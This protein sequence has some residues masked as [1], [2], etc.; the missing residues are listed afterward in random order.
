[1]P[2]PIGGERE[3]PLA[4]TRLGETGD[5]AQQRGLAAAGGA[6]QAQELALADVEI[7]RLERRQPRVETLADAP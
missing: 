5:D 2:I 1:M 3:T 4:L 6:D 7:D